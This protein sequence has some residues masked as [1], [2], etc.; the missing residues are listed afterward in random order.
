LRD[1][2]AR[3]DRLPKANFVGKD[4]AAIAKSAQREDDR[5]DLMRVW[6]DL[7]RPLWSG[8]ATL[9]VRATEPNEILHEVATL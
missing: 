6:V 9:L 3:L 8:V 7:G 1:H 5:L 4:A 2:Q